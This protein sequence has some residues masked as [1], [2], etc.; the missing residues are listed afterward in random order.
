TPAAAIRRVGEDTPAA[1]EPE[2]TL[3]NPPPRRSAPALAS[4]N[5]LNVR[6]GS[7]AVIFYSAGRGVDQVQGDKPAG[8][9]PVPGLDDKMRDRISSRI[10]DHA[11]DLATRTVRAA[12]PGPDH[13]LCLVCHC[14]LPFPG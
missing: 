4:P 12:C 9:P 3:T 7:V 6:S 8:M 5:R 14:R 11:A 2:R 10:D 13:E 1:P